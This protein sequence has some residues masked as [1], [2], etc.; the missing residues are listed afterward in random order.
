MG[1]RTK[2]NEMRER[3]QLK[4]LI[5]DLFHASRYL[6]SPMGEIFFSCSNAAQYIFLF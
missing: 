4:A 3:I 6:L 1:V 5:L 2:K